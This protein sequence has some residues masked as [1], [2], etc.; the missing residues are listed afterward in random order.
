MNTCHAV[1]AYGLALASGPCL[2]VG[3]NVYHLQLEKLEASVSALV[4]E[5]EARYEPPGPVRLRFFDGLVGEGYGLPTEAGLEAIRLLASLEGVLL[6]PV[7]SG[8]GMSGLIKAVRDGEF[9][10]SEDV[11]FLH[12]GGAAALPVYH[13]AFEHDAFE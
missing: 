9:A 13:D 8:K 6:D 10:S 1:L 12:T 4:S 7:Y 5:L 2:N 3:V 11:I